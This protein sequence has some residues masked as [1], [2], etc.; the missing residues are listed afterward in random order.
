MRDVKQTI[1]FLISL[2]QDTAQIQMFTTLVQ[3]ADKLAAIL[4]TCCR[5]AEKN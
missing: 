4:C 5:K 3:K 2:R 1:T